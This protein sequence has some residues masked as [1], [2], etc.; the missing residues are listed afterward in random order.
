MQVTSLF[1]AT[2][3]QREREGRDAN[4]QLDHEWEAAW[5]DFLAPYKSFMHLFVLQLAKAMDFLFLSISALS[6][7][8]PGNCLCALAS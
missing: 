4:E 7:S 6:F 5:S 3:I 1:Q 2:T 8:Q